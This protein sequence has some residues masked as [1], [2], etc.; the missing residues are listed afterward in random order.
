MQCLN[1]NAGLLAGSDEIALQ[2]RCGDYNTYNTSQWSTWSPAE[3]RSKWS[4]HEAHE[5][6]MWVAYTCLEGSNLINKPCC[7]LCKL[8][9]RA[10]HEAAQSMLLSSSV[11]MSDHRSCSASIVKC[12]PAS[13]SSRVSFLVHKGD[14][15]IKD[16][17]SG[18]CMGCIFTGT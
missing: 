11:Q 15:T 9:M 10:S 2:Y 13:N 16:I 14:D 5:A 1:E 17:L 8:S 6:S 4:C 3:A 7:I 12:W 18:T